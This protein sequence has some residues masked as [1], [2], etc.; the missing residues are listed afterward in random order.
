MEYV[1]YDVIEGWGS[2]KVIFSW[3]D[4]SIFNQLDSRFGDEE[5]EIVEF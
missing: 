5:F 1:K 3:V 4:K 2:N